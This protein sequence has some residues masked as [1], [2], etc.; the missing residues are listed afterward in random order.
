MDK[1]ASMRAFVRVVESGSFAGAAREMGLTRSAVNKLVV[2]LETDLGAQL[3]QRTTRRVSPTALG[4]AYYDRCRNILSDVEAADLAVAQLQAEP[5]GLLRA[6]APMSF[7]MSHLAPIL[8]EFMGRYPELQV[9]LHLSDRFVDP[10]EEGFDLTLRIAA[11][12]ET[13]VL[14]AQ[15]LTPIPR[16]LCAAP[17]Y[18]QQFGMPTQ[19]KELRNRACLQY[20]LLSQG[21]R[22]KLSGPDGEHAIAIRPRLWANNGEVLREAALQGL[23]IALLPTFIVGDCLATGQL[24]VV[25]PDYAPPEIAAHAVYPANR[26]LS[27]K[28]RLLVDFLAERLAEPDWDEQ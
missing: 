17:A 19:P 20:G 8:A 23:G 18:L 12:A 2:N 22:W 4:L 28:V 15:K 27:M 3:L 1:L 5:K 11:V 10:I 6:N 21:D 26:Y 13:G 7:G 25:L 16:V 24:Q 9:Q 14:I